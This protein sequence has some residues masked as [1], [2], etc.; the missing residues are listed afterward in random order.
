MPGTQEA[1][2]KSFV[3]PKMSPGFSCSEACSSMYMMPWELGWGY[4][5]WVGALHPLYPCV[6]SRNDF[7]WTGSSACNASP[8][9]PALPAPQRESVLQT[10]ARFSGDQ[11]S[12]PSGEEAAVRVAPRQ[13]RC[14]PRLSKPSSLGAGE[15]HHPPFLGLPL[16][17]LNFIRAIISNGIKRV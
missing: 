15:G 14:L 3:L 16:S 6:A 12:C 8:S 13:A 9:R 1:L 11:G 10:G 4:C 7:F 5:L 2:S 17:T